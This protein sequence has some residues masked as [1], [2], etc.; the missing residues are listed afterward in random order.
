MVFFLKIPTENMQLFQLCLAATTPLFWVSF[1]STRRDR[2]KSVGVGPYND[3]FLFCL[4][5]KD[6]CMYRCVHIF[7]FFSLLHLLFVSASC[8]LSSV[9]FPV[10]FRVC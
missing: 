6:M 5:V 1:D 4:A 7:F 9:S 3:I 2:T 8:A 10:H